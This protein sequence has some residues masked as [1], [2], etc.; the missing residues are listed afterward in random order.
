MLERKKW[1]QEKLMLCIISGEVSWV[2]MGIVW[3]RSLFVGYAYP[4]VGSLRSLQ[5]DC[6]GTPIRK[7][8]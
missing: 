2:V 8:R 1:Q 3:L 4:F 7:I 6:F 5:T